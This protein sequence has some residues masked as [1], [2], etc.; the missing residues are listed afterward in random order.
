[1]GIDYTEYKPL[2]TTINSM[3]SNPSAGAWVDVSVF[4]QP[5]PNQVRRDNL[6]KLGSGTTD[7]VIDRIQTRN[8]EQIVRSTDT[9]VLQSALNN[10][11]TSKYTREAAVSELERRGIKPSTPSNTTTAPNQR[12]GG[13][14][15]SFPTTQSV[16]N[17]MV[18]ATNKYS[19]IR[20]GVALAAPTILGAALDRF[21]LNPLADAISKPIAD[22][23]RRSARDDLKA[24]GIADLDAA[25]AALA[26]AQK[27]LDNAI[28]QREG[29][30]AD[31][32]K[33]N[34]YAPPIT[35]PAPFTGGQSQGVRYQVAFQVWATDSNG[36]ETIRDGTN[37]KLP[38]G[39]WNFYVN[40][41]GKILGIQIV[42]TATTLAAFLI[43]SNGNIGLWGTAIG[44][45]Q[46]SAR[47]LILEVRRE[48]R[49]PDTGGDLPA[50][51]IDPSPDKSEP[52]KLPDKEEW[53]YGDINIKVGGSVQDIGDT[54]WKAQTA[55][56]NPLPQADDRTV[57]PA[58][59]GSSD[60]NRAKLKV[61]SGSQFPQVATQFAEPPKPLPFLT[62]LTKPSFTAKP[63]V[64]G[65]SNPS[66]RFEP[67][68][69]K[70]GLTRKQQEEQW[71]AA[72]QAIQDRAKEGE[73]A[74]AAN[75]AL[76]IKEQLANLSDIP[77]P[78]NGGISPRQQAT[79]AYLNSIKGDAVK[80]AA[81]REA[82]APTKPQNT[83]PTTPISTTTPTTTDNNV[84]QTLGAIAAVTGLVTALKI[85]SDAF[86][87]A[88]LPKINNIEQNTTPTAQQTNAKQGV[89]DAM[90][91]N[92]CGY[93]GVKAATTDATAPIKADSSNLLQNVGALASLVD[94][95]SNKLDGVKTFL[96]KAARAARLD[97][98]YNL[99]TFLTVIH[100]ASML[101]NSVATTLMDSLSLG[102]ATFGIK[103]E[104]ESPI[105]IQQIINKSVEDTVKG[106]IGTANYNTLSERWKSAVRVYQ[107]GANMLYQV[108][109]LWDSARSLNELTGANVGRIGN[110]LRRDGVVAENAY[111]AMPDNPMMVNSAM[112]RLQNLEEAASHLSSI[113]SETYGITE[114]VAQIKKDQDD[115]K[116]LV[117]ESPITNGTPN[118]AQKAKD[119]AAKSASVSPSIST[120]DL[121]KP[122]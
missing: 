113:T 25:D 10:V 1:M 114:T 69:V 55:P 112:T 48:D 20:G 45:N 5:H 84:G 75:D 74:A 62:N 56:F 42:A 52:R 121:V 99:L 106:V 14:I 87:N 73:K 117:K 101:S 9:S 18:Q 19:P 72:N 36:I 120:T 21:V 44:T 47:A 91:P 92:Q 27:K 100:N 61:K 98:V 16:A 28:K 4:K 39:D 80:E 115:F 86:V 54:N 59:S 7:P 83:T 93:E 13:A 116:K 67:V 64:A 2:K 71:V 108:R 41:T 65:V 43:T 85:G 68:D 17:D 78:A 90:Q 22:A 77:N 30:L 57:E 53:L 102:L 50:Q 63:F 34:N 96:E 118:D 49:Q 26:N 31:E 12:S 81:F 32:G 82:V 110:A 76:K 29:R 58:P 6:M 88:S 35:Q 38:N 95:T 60:D 70:T 3:P 104:N 46:V 105:D 23:L 107:A 37:A 89:C 103:D 51:I 40:A 122:D 33:I 15:P 119:D 24:R 66:E 94:A 111:P 109:S 8:A 11:G 97:K 79:Q